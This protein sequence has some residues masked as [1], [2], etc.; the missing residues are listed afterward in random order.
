[1]ASSSHDFVVD[2]ISSE[3]ECENEQVYHKRP[4]DVFSITP[5]KNI[6]VS[7][8]DTF[9]G[10]ID[11]NFELQDNAIEAV[12][13][14][15][16]S[17]KMESF[18]PT[19]SI[20]YE[21]D[22]LNVTDNGCGMT[23]GQLVACLTPGGTKV[24]DTTSLRGDWQAKARELRRTGCAGPG[25]F[26]FADNMGRY[27]LGVYAL[28]KIAHTATI[29][30]HASGD[31]HQYKYTMK[32]DGWAA[33]NA[34]WEVFI[35]PLPSSPSLDPYTSVK[36]TLKPSLARSS[37]SF[38]NLRTNLMRTYVMLGHP[39]EPLPP[40]LNSEVRH[41]MADK[42][43]PQQLEPLRILLNHESLLSTPEALSFHL[44]ST[45]RRIR[46]N[47]GLFRLPMGSSLDDVCMVTLG[48][49]N[50]LHGRTALSKE[51][52]ETRFPGMF[53]VYWQ[54]RYIFSYT[55][56]KLPRIPCRER[57][58][59]EIHLS[60]V[61]KPMTDKT[62]MDESAQPW[63]KLTEVECLYIMQWFLVMY[64]CVFPSI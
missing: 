8:A 39:G 62:S 18:M 61:F 50:T 46:S 56:Q 44:G 54:G 15:L 30:T 63:K 35:P 19:V 11:K 17:C 21:H 47:L 4:T 57:V 59:G 27:G 32:R 13:K 5:K 37:E 28:L 16:A 41:P 52:L 64:F 40:V 3:D 60:S 45:L 25:R 26:I 33:D 48:Y 53:S 12:R 6:T 38:A 1:M 24:D 58:R 31:A 42:T 34:D 36:L 23:Q 55:P 20:L 49:I 10:Q 22:R 7:V 9:E 29:E 43:L 14:I 51:E 2:I